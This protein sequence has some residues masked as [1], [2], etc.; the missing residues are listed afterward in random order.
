MIKGFL[1]SPTLLPGKGIVKTNVIL[2]G[3]TIK[4]ISSTPLTISKEDF[5]ELPEDLILVPGFID[6]HI[7]GSDGVDTM[8]GTFSSLHL[9]ATSLLQDGVTSFCPTTMSMNKES[10]LKALSN[11]HNYIHND[12]QDGS[13]V[14]G[15]HLEGPF[16]SKT[17]KGAQDE[18][19]IIP[20]D[21]SLFKSFQTACP[22]IKIV[23]FA[24]EENGDELLEY[25]V[26]ENITASIGHSN[27]CSKMLE[28]GIKKGISCATH[29]FNAMSPLH[30]RE[31]GT[32]GGVLF[33]D[34]LRC[35]LIADLIHVSP[36]AIKLLHK[37]ADNRLILITD[38]M[39][40]KHKKEGIYSLGGQKV[41]VKE[42]AARLEN[43]TLA[44]SILTM[45]QALKNMKETLNE[46]FENLINMA[47]I[48]P[49]KNLKIDDTYGSIEVGKKADFVVIDSSFNVKATIV[50]GKILYK[51][52][53]MTC[54]Q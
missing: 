24:Y 31:I 38:S 22:E 1:N 16:I 41:I 49:A 12:P 10:I 29:T 33:S 48:I 19:D 50:G 52:E 30:H 37:C 43:G 44:G 32:V 7:H 53:E 8:E 3:D 42:G 17:F 13:R 54:L 28:K 2:D 36:N 34:T 21:V 20:C 5:I 23:T 51:E 6:E 45:P 9:I 15:A 18:K 46:S 25:M 4:S 39:E 47:S 40:A 35:E 27:C 14:L 26:K 11:I